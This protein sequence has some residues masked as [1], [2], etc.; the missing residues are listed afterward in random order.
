[1]LADCAKAETSI[2]LEQ[3]IYSDDDFGNK[4][5]DVC[6]ERAAKGVKV[7]FLWDAYGSFTF[8]GSN[9]MTELRAKGI[10]L[11]LPKFTHIPSQSEETV[12]ANLSR[13]EGKP[14]AAA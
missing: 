7:R 2:V 11:V 1:M 12:K 9:I 4:L 10:E 13:L 6:A 14:S 5:I 8:W 3:F